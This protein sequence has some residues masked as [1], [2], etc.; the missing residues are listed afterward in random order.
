MPSC[1]E[2]VADG[3]H[4]AAGLG[5]MEREQLLHRL[6]SER[7]LLEQ[8]LAREGVD[9]VAHRK[10]VSERNLCAVRN[11]AA[12]AEDALQEIRSERA[13]EIS[14]QLREVEHGMQRLLTAPDH[15]GRCAR[16]EQA[17]AAERLEVLPS[18]TLC[19]RCAGGDKQV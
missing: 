11:P 8:R 17:I 6:K 19:A 16:C 5:A 2:A 3:M 1:N 15:F 10:R 9:L 18:T 14:R 7:A 4:D 13:R 12:A